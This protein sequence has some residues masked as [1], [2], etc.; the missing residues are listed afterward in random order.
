M[1]RFIL[2]LLLT[3][4]VN[5]YSLDFN[6]VLNSITDTYEIRSSQMT[7]D[8]LEK[9]VQES[10]N[11]GDLEVTLSPSLKAVN[12][13]D[14]SFVDDIEY[15]GTVS[16]VIPLG[17]SKIE[18]EKLRF[19]SNDLTS[20][21]L[22]SDKIQFTT[23]IKLYGL[24]KNL[25][26]IQAEEKIIQLELDAATEYSDVLNN[27]FKSGTT[28]LL[29]LNNSIEDKQEVETSLYENQLDQR[30]AMY[31]LMFTIGT[32]IEPEPL[33]QVDIKISDLPNAKEL[34]NWMIMNDPL[35]KIEKVNL[36]EILITR[37]RLNDSDIDMSIKPFYNSPGNDFSSS[38]NY[39]LTTKNLTPSIT[40]NVGNDSDTW[41]TGLTMNISLGSNKS[42]LLETETLSIEYQIAEAKLNLLIETLNLDLKKSYQKYLQNRELVLQA[43]GYYNNAKVGNELVLT[44][45]ELGQLSQYELLESNANLLR[46]KWK[47]DSAVKEYQLSWLSVLENSSWF[48]NIDIK[49]E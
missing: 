23:F 24:Y 27:R 47:V 42:D 6:T 49:Y 41:S 5:I 46:A 43:E 16:I 12:P 38:I 18:R 36:S 25:W 7:I 17:L 48:N 13:E 40:M 1:R 14:S 26:L 39:N 19:A 21:R 34:Y 8:K 9:E 11:P 22:N 33:E 10:K 32:L 28:T 30:I 35:I 20:T 37:D 3:Q 44:K 29:N 2:I 31:E 15:T 4:F 45:M